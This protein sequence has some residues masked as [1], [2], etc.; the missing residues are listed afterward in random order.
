LLY[1]RAQYTEDRHGD[2]EADDRVCE[3]PPERNTSGAEE[4]GQAGE[5]VGARMQAVGNEGRAADPPADPDPIPRDDL[6][7]DEP[8]DGG[9]RDGPQVGDGAGVDEPVD[10]F[11]GC[12]PAGE[13]DH[14][15]HE[16]ATQILGPSVA[17]GVARSGRT[18]REPERDQQRHGS[19][20][21]G[22][23]VQGIAEERDRP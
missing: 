23:V 12:Q 14:R 15:D 8:D 17:V 16:Q 7:A 10:R 20:R 11:V 6:V 1:G 4:H 21:V 5:P 3:P 9:A 2:Q 19:E 18:A 13:R 22:D